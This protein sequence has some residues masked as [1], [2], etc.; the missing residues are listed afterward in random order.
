[1]QKKGRELKK[2]RPLEPNKSGKKVEFFV[3][4]HLSPLPLS[5]YA[6]AGKEA[7]SVS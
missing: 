4:H 6:L 5:N 2:K 3:P 1:M 7:N